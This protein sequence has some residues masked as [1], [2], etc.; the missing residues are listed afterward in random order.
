MPRRRSARSST[1]PAPGSF[2]GYYKNAEATAARTRGGRFHTGDLGYRDEQGYVYFAGR[3]VEWLRVDGENFL[4]RPVEEILQRHPD[5]VLAAV[6]G[7]P[8]AEA[9]DRVMAALELRP[10]AR[11]DPDGFARFLAAQPDLSPQVGADLRPGRGGA[12][13]LGDQ[14]GGEARAA[15]RGLPRRRTAP[16]RSGGV[17][18]A[19]ARYRPF[20]D[21]AT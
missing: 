20:S 16:T 9:G 13:P 15:A 4:A 11:F 8:D 10:G 2:E 5:V 3:D 14:Q 18:A 7:V 12:P 19:P 21:R 6:Y 1:R 17:R